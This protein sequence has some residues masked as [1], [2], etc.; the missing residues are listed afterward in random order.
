MIGRLKVTASRKSHNP[1][2]SVQFSDHDWRSRESLGGRTFNTIARVC[3]SILLRIAPNGWRT[4]YI[5]MGW[6][7]S[8]WTELYSYL[9][10]DMQFASWNGGL[11][12]FLGIQ[13]TGDKSD[14]HRR[15]ILPWRSWHQHAWET[16]GK[17]RVAPKV[18]EGLWSSRLPHGYCS[19]M[20]WLGEV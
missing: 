20:S 11:L 16:G 6:S 1:W 3:D 5:S 19:L 4:T 10:S 2:P 13:R 12:G 7:P 18:W 9:F 8:V 14:G 15:Q 17:A